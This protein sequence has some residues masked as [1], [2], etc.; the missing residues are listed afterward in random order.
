MNCQKPDHDSPHLVCGYPLPCP[1][2]TVQVVLG[3][4]VPV[5]S[6]PTTLKISPKTLGKVSAIANVLSANISVQADGVEPCA[7][8][9]ISYPEGICKACGE[10]VDPRR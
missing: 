7:H 4:P 6:I 8:E 9:V 10:V 3:N 2:H 5:V 1:Y